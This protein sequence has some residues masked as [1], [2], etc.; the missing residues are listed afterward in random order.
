MVTRKPVGPP[1]STPAN[2]ANSS[3][4]P[5]Y[6][7]TPATA[8]HPRS[9]GFTELDRAKTIHSAKSVYSPDLHSSPAF[10]LIDMNEA[11]QRPRRDSDVSSHGTWDSEDDGERGDTPEEEAL[12][13]PKPLRISK[14][15]QDINQHQE[16]VRGK[17]ELPAVLKPGPAGGIHPR[18]SEEELRYEE[19]AQGNPWATSTA[20]ESSAPSYEQPGSNNP[21]RQQ[22]GI[23]PETSENAWQNQQLLPPTSAPPAPPVELSTAPK[24]PSDE[25]SKL[26]LGEHHEQRPEMKPFET[27]EILAVPQQDRASFSNMDEPTESN[28]QAFPPSNPW[29]T[30]SQ[31]RAPQQYNSAPPPLSPAPAA[32][33]QQY[34]PPPGPPPKGIASTS[35]VD[36]ESPPSQQMPSMP[37]RATAAPVPNTH[38][39]SRSTDVVLETPGARAQEQR[40]E[41]YQIK[42]VNWFDASIHSMRRSPILTQNANGPCPLLALVNALVLTTPQNLDTAL[43]ETLRTREQVSLGLL[44][45][46][47]FDELMSGRRGDTASELPDVDELYAFLLALHTG[48]NVNPRFVT[49]ATAPRGSLDGA[50]PGKAALH[51]VE[52]AQLKA[53]CFEETKEMRLYSTFN[54]PLIHGW[55]APRGTEAYTAFE[56]C[57]QTFEEAQNMQFLEPELEEKSREE[58]LAPEEQLTLDDIRTIRRFLSTWST[59]LTDYGLETIVASLRPGQTAILFRN[60]H[61]STIYREPKHGAL[62]TLVTDAGYGT[63]EEIVWESLVDVN[64][65]ASEMFSG[66]FRAV[67]HGEDVRLNPS[68]SGGDEGRET[69]QGR[70]RDRQS[71]SGQDEQTAPPLPGPRPQHSATTGQP[72]ALAAEAPAQQR[73]ASEQQD[74]DL[75]LALQ[76][77]EEEEDQQRQAEQRRRREQELSERFLSTE[78]SPT[79]GARPP[80]PPR[81]SGN[82]NTTGRNSAAPTSG[83]PAVNRPATGG[84]DPDAPPTYEQ[85]R[86]DRPYRPAG[87]T[88]QQ[89]LQQGNPLSAYDALRNQQGGSSTNINANSAGSPGAQ[90]RR[91][92]QTPASNRVGGRRRSQMGG[93]GA[94]PGAGRVM[95][96]T[97]GSGAAPSGSQ[98]MRPNQAAG[99]RDAEEKCAVM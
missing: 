21:Y 80:V 85:S 51:P 73:S 13:V 83:R 92:S 81:R 10:D 35:L 67:S 9:P 49:P 57:A 44:L 48:M 23:A 54:V 53:G 2:D 41:H 86:S 20:A 32:L 17:E 76:L 37:V 72:D 79:E 15:Q 71:R 64:G 50:P 22:H 77:Q 89:N 31:E 33:H 34:A 14:S 75:A 88:A 27:A 46:A 84:G 42:H 62:M 19:E 63:H 55:T 5:P 43:V 11:R 16:P 96:G 68:G 3:S 40:S 78:S 4:N 82:N 1:L 24:T 39:P 47:V 30:P 98:V 69:V 18:K 90:G 58:G 25:L 99:V 91:Q 7:T 97:Y 52:R 74:H 6:P 66:D 12:N 36:S 94:G 38:P 60:D 8:T 87:A 61:F 65:A 26:S 95:P 59:Q 70:R 29:R 93:P 28:C 45:D 56:R